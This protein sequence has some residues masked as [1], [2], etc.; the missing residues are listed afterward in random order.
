MATWTEVR[1]A[2]EAARRRFEDHDPYTH[3]HSV[4]VSD[5]VMM[6]ASH[7]PGFTPERLRRLE[8]T[9]LLHDF[10]KTFLDPELIRKP[11]NL[12]DDEWAEMRRHPDL[13]A[14]NVPVLREF[15]VEEGI[16]WHH[17]HY[18]GSGYPPGD[19]KGHD[20]PLEARLI[21][22]ADVFDALSSRRAYRTGTPAFKPAEAIEI[23]RGMAGKELDPG[24]VALFQTLYE[25]ECARVGGEAGAATL[26]VRGVISAEIERAHQILDDVIGPHD[27]ARPLKGKPVDSGVLKSL[28]AGL[29]RA[30]IDAVSARAIARHVLHMEQEETFPPEIMASPPEPVRAAEG[31]VAHHAEIV[32][33]LSRCPPAADLAHVVVFRGDL[34]LSIVERRDNAIEARLSR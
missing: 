23:M 11:G 21:A 5:W 31:S 6:M 10:G 8:V 18:D 26:Q 16:R 33:R 27:R 13:G 2:A 9:A 20:L 15:V 19:V 3:Q 17:K 30:S 34:W 1:V 12:S 24:L 32:L 7:V 4:R 29:V 28:V 25:L 22:V 14:D